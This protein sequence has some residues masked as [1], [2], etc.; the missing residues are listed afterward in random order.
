MRQRL[1]LLLATVAALVGLTALPAGALT[2]GGNVS[3][4]TPWMASLQVGGKHACGGTLVAAQWVL[5]AF[6]CVIKPT[7]IEQIRIGSRNHTSGGVVAKPVA[8]VKHPKAVF[9]PPNLFSGVDLTLIKLD[10][11]VPFRP[12]GL[13]GSSPGPGTKLDLLGWGWTCSDKPDCDSP[14]HLKQIQLPV[15]PD[16]ECFQG[17]DR[18]WSLCLPS[19]RGQGTCSGDSGGPALVRSGRGW[20]LAGVTS[21]GGRQDPAKPVECGSDNHYNAY[22]EVA[23]ALNWIKDTTR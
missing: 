19:Q 2:N 23:P 10:R 18:P 16:A 12:M 15:A 5:T 3:G 14:A 20:R 11:P 6:H 9:T 7:D 1:L 4:P 8:A 13:T 22:T 21:G 17:K